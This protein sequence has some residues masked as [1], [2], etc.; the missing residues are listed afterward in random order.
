ML[1]KIKLY[2]ISSLLIN[3]RITSFLLVKHT[4]KSIYAVLAIL[5]IGFSNQVTAQTLQLGTLSS[6][7]AYTGSGAVTNNGTA[8]GDAGTN[9]G[10]IS[11][12]GF[13][14]GYS[15]TTHN[16]NAT[17]VQARIDLLKVYIHLDDVFVTYPSSHA[18]AFGGGETI[19]PGVYS[20]GGAGSIAGNLTLDGGGNSNAFFII[21]FEGA[22]T[23]GAGSKIILSN[24]TQA[25]NVFWISQGAISVA[26]DCAIK[27]T[28]F[29]HPGAVTLGVDSTIEGR[30]LTSERAITIAAGAEAAIP[31]GD[32]SIQI[33]CL[34]V[35]VSNSRV[36]VL[37]SLGSFALFTS[38][39]A[40]ANAASSGIVGDIG[41]NAGAITGFGTSTHEGSFYTANAVTAQAKIDLDIAYTALMDLE[42][43]ETGHPAAF[44]NG[45]T[46]YT[47]VY[48]IGGAGSLGG[49]IT[50]DAQDDPDAIFVF[51]FAGAFSVA[52]QSRVILT[53][54]ARRC[55][56]FWIGGAGVATGAVSMGTFTYMKGTV[57]SHGGACTMGANGSMEGRML[58]TGGAIGF[59]TGVVYN[60]TLCFSPTE[61][62]LVIDAVTDTT[63]AV[64]GTTGG[65]TTSLTSNDTLG[66]S[67]V[68]I[69]TAP[70]NVTLTGLSVPAGLSLNANGTV[71][72]AANT[73]AGNYSLTYKICEVSNTAN[74][75]SVTSTIV[76][77]VPV[78]PTPP[79]ID[80]VTD[81][82]AAVNGTTGGTTTSLTS[83]DTL[84][85]SAVVIGTAPGNVTLTGLSV[86]AGLSLNANGTVTIAAN[87]PAGNYILE[88]KICEV[89]NTTNC[90]S[91]KSTIEVFSVFSDFTPT[92]DIDT[93]VFLS[94]ESSKD[95]V[96]YISEINGVSSDGQVIVKL[97]K[98]NSFIISYD[99]DTTTS[100]VNGVIIV[101]NSDWIITESLTFI[102]MKLKPSSIIR[103]NTFS[104]IGFKIKPQLDIPEKTSLPI[105]VTILN[106]SGLDIYNN[107][108]TF[109]IVAE[110]R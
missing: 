106:N 41:T 62:V 21:K 28:M 73:P 87:T 46:I 38:D 69:G 57:I 102:T 101:N 100:Y 98:G 70:G 81:T 44:G 78:P 17:T 56:I 75:D 45:E 109:S 58:S 67:A 43:T 16:N 107:N 96:V 79:I 37:G 15:G 4:I 30:L 55:N 51:K 91:V 29:A 5:L 76:I 13:G 12:S 93:P 61:E 8:S 103:G 11:G 82:T 110:V 35:C 31:I 32:S 33:K 26:T 94:T 20:I 66:G 22:L 19:T 88:Y 83:N 9:D 71:T 27:G 77:S 89:S 65:T 23:V 39:G 95:F 80:A 105:T 99:N 14:T 50:L 63:A 42:N 74:C 64:N 36:N 90:D 2:S 84:G 7:E 97:T 52:A 24:G 85:G 108:N 54:G 25:A 34:G 60:D 53:N 48:S 18:P 47:G 59:S 10:I 68:V 104:A 6:F 86:P 40:V 1:N 3:F 92:I 49:T 72:I